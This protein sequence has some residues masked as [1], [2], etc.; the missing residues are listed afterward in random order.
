MET[1]PLV[2]YP[3]AP[4]DLAAAYHV[5]LDVV[6]REIRDGN[7]HAVRIRGQ[8][9]ISAEAVAEWGGAA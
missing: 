3:Y 4:A 6:Y 1:T 9:R 5:S 7:L 8:Y 2:Q